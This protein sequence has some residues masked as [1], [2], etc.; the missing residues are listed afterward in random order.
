MIGLHLHRY[1]Y[2]WAKCCMKET[3]INAWI[4]LRKGKTKRKR[5]KEVEENF[6]YWVNYVQEILINT[7]PGGNP[8]K[9]FTP[10]KHKVKLVFEHGK[11]REIYRPGIIEQWV[12]HVVIQVLGPIIN[13]YS[14]KYS[15]GSMPNRGGVYGKKYLERQIKYH[16]GF[17]YYMKLDIRHFFKHVRISIVLHKLQTFI[18][19]DWL[20]FL[21]NRIF[22]HF[23]IGMPLGF[24]PSQWLANYILSPID[25]MIVRSRP[26]AYIRYVD[27]MIICDN[28]KR[29]LRDIFYKIKRELGKLRLK[30]K[31]N[32]QIVRFYISSKITSFKIWM[33]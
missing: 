19:D 6:E 5:V 33:V 11:E 14:Y 15:C 1:K 29:R 8:D 7:R 13:K 20:I 31:S 2:L 21:I 22:M 27:D 18:E 32:Y 26:K 17:K 28:S 3:I 4:K 23:K 12:H 30:V 24:Y 9:M 10:P 16:R 25:F